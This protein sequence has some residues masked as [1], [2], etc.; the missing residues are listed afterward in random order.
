VASEKLFLVTLDVRDGIQAVSESRV[1][2]LI[3]TRKLE[4]GA[5]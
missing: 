2:L 3:V 5:D 4:D 1:L